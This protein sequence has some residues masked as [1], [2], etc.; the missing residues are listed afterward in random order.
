MRG[1]M[2][3]PPGDLSAQQIGLIA[4]GHRQAEDHAGRHPSGMS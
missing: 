1:R 4:A 3:H 2:P